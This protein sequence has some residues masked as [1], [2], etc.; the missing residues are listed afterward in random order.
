MLEKRIQ[1]WYFYFIGEKIYGLE[2][3]MDHAKPTMR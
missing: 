2:S 3:G 1:F